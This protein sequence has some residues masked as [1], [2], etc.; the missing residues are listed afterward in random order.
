[1]IGT[2]V[3]TVEPAGPTP[4]RDT[5]ARLGSRGVEQPWSPHCFRSACTR[6]TSSRRNPAAGPTAR[7]T[8]APASVRF[9][10]HTDPPRPPQTPAASFK[11]LYRE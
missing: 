10:T 11:R 9:N 1:M 2:T 5:C 4:D 7:H 6:W 3:D 8:P